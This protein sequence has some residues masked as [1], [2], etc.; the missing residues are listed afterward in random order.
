MVNYTKL[1]ILSSKLPAPDSFFFLILPVFVVN[2]DDE[3]ILDGS[4][5]SKVKLQV[6]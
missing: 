1:T 3:L 2:V 5:I 4:K 6:I